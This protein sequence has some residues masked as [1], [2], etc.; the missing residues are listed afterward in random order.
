[1]RERKL[2]K[3][4]GFGYIICKKDKEEGLNLGRVTPH[5]VMYWNLMVIKSVDDGMK[6]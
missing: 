6:M 4:G 5:P 1:M 2:F 3:F